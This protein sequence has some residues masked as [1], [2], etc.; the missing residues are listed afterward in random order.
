MYKLVHMLRVS[1][2]LNLIFAVLQRRLIQLWV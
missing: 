2:L 1:N